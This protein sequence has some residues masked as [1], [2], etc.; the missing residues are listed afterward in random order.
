M[1]SSSSSSKKEE[2]SFIECHYCLFG[3]SE[4]SLKYL[5]DLVMNESD[6]VTCP[7]D[8][9]ENKVQFKF[10][11]IKKGS[12]VQVKDPHTN[13]IKE[14]KLVNVKIKKNIFHTHPLGSKPYPS[15]EDIM[16]VIKRSGEICNSFVATSWGIWI[17]SNT[18]KSQSAFNG[19][20]ESFVEDIL[21]DYTKVLQS[22]DE[23]M[24]EL[25]RKK[26]IERA[27][28]NIK[29]IPSESSSKY[30][31]SKYGKVM[32]KT[33]LIIKFISWSEISKD[34]NINIC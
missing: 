14:R 6:E 25:Y 28:P 4:D 3:F 11:K 31:N 15:I 34:I 30:I 1:S 16:K 18:I 32:T 24:Y 9:V 5:R 10:D 26:H 2:K 29:Y 19:E 13:K 7:V 17:I 23:Q 22:V 21:R 27:N 8:L 33:N 20:S 12:I